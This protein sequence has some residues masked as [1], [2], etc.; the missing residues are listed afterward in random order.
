MPTPEKCVDHLGNEFNS[1][2]KMC[3]QWGISLENYNRRIKNGWTQKDALETSSWKGNNSVD[4][5]GNEFRSVIDMC[6]YWKINRA[7]YEDRIKAGWSIKNAL[8]FHARDAYKES[9]DHLNQ[10]FSSIKDMCEYWG[11]VRTVYDSRI[12]KL[13]WSLKDTLESPCKS[14][15]LDSN[16]T[17]MELLE[18][19]FYKVIYCNQLDIWTY[20][21]LMHYYRSKLESSLAV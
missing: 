8:E 7:T 19:G 10:K 13:G 17:S 5:L 6:K 1:K 2:T 9:I 18:H 4:H 14:I 3:K 21:E 20:D 16:L 11:I 15:I 12:D